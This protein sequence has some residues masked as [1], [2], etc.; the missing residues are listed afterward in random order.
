MG[1][2]SNDPLVLEAFFNL[3][4]HLLVELAGLILLLNDVVDC[5]SGGEISEGISA[6]ACADPLVGPPGFRPG[7]LEQQ[8]PDF[9]RAG[10]AEGWCLGVTPAREFII[11]PDCLPDAIPTDFHAV[12]SKLVRLAGDEEVQNSFGDLG[13]PAQG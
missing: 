13:E 8:H 12:E 10:L 11:D 7:L 6:Q 4:E 9:V 3:S 2:A 5:W 1:P